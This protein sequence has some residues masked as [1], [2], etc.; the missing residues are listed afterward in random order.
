MIKYNPKV[1]LDQD[2]SV[3]NSNSTFNS[4]DFVGFF[5]SW[6]QHPIVGKKS[7]LLGGNGKHVLRYFQILPP[8]EAEE[9][10]NR[11]LRVDPADGQMYDLDDFIKEYGGSYQAPPRR[12][13]EQALTSPGM[14]IRGG[15]ERVL[16]A[17]SISSRLYHSRFL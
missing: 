8:I 14:L 1:K 11:E 6:D 7:D 2:N 13:L 5:F 9:F 16:L 3:S 15:N 10:K 17:N 4:G 12:W